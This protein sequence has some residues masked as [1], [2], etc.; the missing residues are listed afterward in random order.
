VK[1]SSE[2]P[3]PEAVRLHL[4][5]IL[6]SQ[7]FA[8]A[9]SLARFLSFVVEETLEGRGAELKEYLIGV[10]VFER[11]EAFD[12][13]IDPIVR[14]QAG[15]LRKRLQEYYENE[16]SADGIRIGLQKGSYTPVIG[17]RIP[18]EGSAA[19]AA[20]AQVP[21]AHPS[22]PA[23][24][25]L[26]WRA[27][28][29]FVV[30]AGVFAIWRFAQPARTQESLRL[31]LSRLTSDSGQTTHPTISDDGRLLAFSSDRGTRGDANIWVQPLSGGAPTQ[32][33]HNPAADTSPDFSPGGSSLVFR[34][35]REGGG[36]YAVSVLGGQ[37]RRIAAGGYSPRYSPDGKWVAFA[38]DGI[39]VIPATGGDPIR[40]SG[41]VH[42][43]ACPLWTP[44]GK[45]LI[46]VGAVKEGYDW[47]VVSL[48]RDRPAAP[49]GVAAQLRR[50]GLRDFDETACPSDWMGTEVVF[51]LKVDGMGNLWSVPLSAGT[52]KV[53]G[54]ARQL[55]PGPGIDHPRV[56]YRAAEPFRL[57]FATDTSV[58]HLWSLPV[59]AARGVGRGEMEQMTRDAS[60]VGGVEGTRPLLSADGLR[61]VFSSARSGNPDIW[62]K[63]L[64]TGK[65][66]SLTSNPGPDDQPV[67]SSNLDKVAYQVL[68]GRRRAIYTVDLS[69]RLPHKLCDE[70]E[71]PMDMS[72]DGGLLLY[73][74]AEP[75]GLHL[76][77][78]LTG[79]RTRLLSDPVIVSI[80]ASFSLDMRWI[81]LV[82]RKQGQEKLKAFIVPFDGTQLGPAG[83]WIPVTEEMYHLYLRWSPDG[84]LLYFFATRDDHR[85]LWAVRLDPETKHPRGE[86]L[87][88]RHFHTVQ[89]YP[90]SGSWLSVVRGRVAFNLTDV[91]SNIWMAAIQ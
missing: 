73:R 26:S 75:W 6:A 19:A 61:L 21:A 35:W 88:V 8:G 39:Q 10:D 66:E 83:S 59:E 37:E 1:S 63:D 57:I 16:G 29:W 15:K 74:G 32:L 30:L 64:T 3:A 4:A 89:H 68:E 82:T 41:D 53:A 56:L 79:T 80:E 44:D 13:R 52:W 55:V 2:H 90:L 46:F 18:G 67:A 42:G 81:A 50:S 24:R 58:S 62:I 65:E 27:A 76:V 72:P 31:S 54:P 34:S 69:S 11:G 71:H 33:T 43:T 47:W 78:T 40:V 17:E 48:D 12:P 5:K 91:T 84:D 86:P 9:P 49:T 7:G 38:Q 36:I 77:N 28:L 14:V 23:T 22:A 25:N 87:A 20:S 60:L 70:C 45:H 51:V 85:C